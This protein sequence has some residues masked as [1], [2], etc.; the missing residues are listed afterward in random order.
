MCLPRKRQTI[1]GAMQHSTDRENCQ[2]ERDV[3]LLCGRNLFLCLE[4]LT[5]LG[6]GQIEP[7]WRHVDEISDSDT[8]S[9]ANRAP[10]ASSPLDRTLARKPPRCTHCLTTWAGPRVGVDRAF[11]NRRQGSQSSTPRKRTPPTVKVLPTSSLRR[12]PRVTTLRPLAEK[13]M[14]PW[15]RAAKASTS[16]ASMNEM[17]WPGSSWASK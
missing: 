5:N 16:S 15:Y 7:R 11:P 1:P 6:P 9:L 12:T 13:S 8:C 17:F 14:L 10:T 4:K 2:A 3:N